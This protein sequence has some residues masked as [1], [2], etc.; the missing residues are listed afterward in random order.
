MIQ[1]HT[2]SRLVRMTFQIKSLLFLDTLTDDDIQRHNCSDRIWLPRA[3]FERHMGRQEAGAVLVLK[4]INGVE[5]TVVGTPFGYHQDS[6]NQ[7][8]VPQWMLEVLEYDADTIRIEPCFPSL[9]SRISIVPF[10]SE[11]LVA[12]DPQIYFRDGFEAYTCIQ[13]GSVLPLFCD[14]QII[15]VSVDD[16]IPNSDEP[17]CIRD[18]ELELDLQRPL[19]RPP[20]PVEANVIEEPEPEPEPKTS[21]PV[22]SPEEIRRLCREAALQRAKQN[23]LL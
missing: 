16:V 18:V 1:T 7:I 21:E 9:C 19:D 10:T 23:T 15:Q 2:M 4:L 8:Y 12:D 11:H 22:V 14:G 20:T 13:R 3:D 5:Q 6:R 17:L